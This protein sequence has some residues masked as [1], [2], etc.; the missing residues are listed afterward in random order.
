[1]DVVGPGYFSTLGIPIAAGR[2]IEEG[3]Q[4]GSAAICVINE[5]FAQ[6][7][8]HQRNP[9]G[10][11]ITSTDD[12]KRTT[13]RVVGVSKN[14][15]THSLR[16]DVDPRY[17][18]PAVQSPTAVPSPT[19]LIRTAAGTAAVMAAVRFSARTPR[20]RSGRRSRLRSSSH[21]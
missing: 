5:A 19:F 14:E 8:F 1:M 6:R 13:Y 16:G 3:D 21:R 7:F 15:R 11:S 20:C 4:A 17:F 2:D 10:M 9:I 18:V 12:D